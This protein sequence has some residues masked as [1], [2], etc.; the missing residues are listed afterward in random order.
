M[1][2]VLV[3]TQEDRLALRDT[4][5][6][7]LPNPNGRPA[8][9]RQWAQAFSL[10]DGLMVLVGLLAAVARFTNLGTQP[11]SPAE[12]D[13]ALASWQFAH[14]VPLA[15][16]PASP[17]YFTFTSLLMSLGGDGDAAARLVP[18]LFGTLTVLLPWL[19]RGR[20]GPAVWLTSGILLAASPIQMVLSRTAGGDAIALFALVL[21][22]VAALPP[23][24]SERWGIAA[25]AGLGL[26]LASSPLFYTGLV[27]FL[28]AWWVFRGA[29]GLSSR[30]LR[31]A[32]VAATVVFLTVAAGGLFY[33]QGIGGA[34]ALLAAW[35][36]QFGLVGGQVR[37]P[38]LVLLRYEIPLV[39]LGLP[40]AVWAI[41]RGPRL[42]MQ[43]VL[44]LGLMLPALLL[45][46]A[47]PQHAAAMLAPGYLLIGLL[48]G[49]LFSGALQSSDRQHAWLVGGGLVLLGMT[50]LLSMGRL[51]MLGMWTGGRASLAGL[52][53]LSFAL[54]ATLVVV[55]LAFENV[56][57]RRGA[58]V[59][60]ALL[61]LYWQ[62]GTGWHLSHHAANN[63]GERWVTVGTDEEVPLL[64]EVVSQVSREATGSNVDLNVFSAVESP[65]LRW[66]FR[67]FDRFAI[68]A[69]LPVNVEA[70]VV[71]T[72]ADAE[73]QL[74][75][76]YFGADFGLEQREVPG[77]S[78]FSESKSTTLDQLMRA[79]LFHRYGV[80]VEYER[81]LVWVRSN[82]A[83]TE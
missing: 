33:P 61:L 12:A 28:P 17:A 78:L 72:R 27:A 29:D 38:L 39:V 48:A 6:S 83:T 23:G 68:G 76:A 18:A 37:E 32:A 66:Y 59:G 4:P 7:S 53:V 31:D 81:L 8:I 56:A 19:W 36:G 54:A 22:A 46:A 52:G 79:W 30:A 80:P 25:G 82:L 74:P 42:A 55:V 71:I 15:G 11:L 10:A 43:L 20:F 40:A 67:H 3:E 34:L 21:L 63:P 65:V 45:Q 1:G 50:M 41:A 35:L 13:A 73:P 57:A 14:G 58:F 5:S 75:D 70:D 60:I 69:T 24:G 2:D 26:G 9:A 64:L 16:S 77:A 44:W 51:T 62:W 47:A 49:A